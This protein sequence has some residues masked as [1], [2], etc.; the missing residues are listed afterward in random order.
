M[1]NESLDE[2]YYQVG[3]LTKTIKKTNVFLRTM[4]PLNINI[5]SNAHDIYEGIYIAMGGYL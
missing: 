4:R 5:L 1:S 3:I 2:E